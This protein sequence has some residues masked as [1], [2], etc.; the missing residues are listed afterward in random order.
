MKRPWRLLVRTRFI[1][2]HQVEYSERRQIG[3]PRE[4]KFLLELRTRLWHIEPASLRRTNMAHTG[5]NV[6]YYILHTLVATVG[7]MLVTALI[8]MQIYRLHHVFDGGVTRRDYATL[9]FSRGS[10][11]QVAI[12]TIAGYV[13]STRY[14]HRCALWVWVPPLIFLTYNLWS[15]Q[16][17]SVFGG[18]QWM[19]AFEHFFG[20][21]CLV[22][23][24]FDQYLVTMP[25]LTAIAYALGTAVDRLGVLRFGNKHRGVPTDCH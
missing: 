19:A 16:P 8:L 11:V 24:C 21:G 7:C 20:R 3:N 23:W 22:P 10:P 15:W 9:L 14:K 4:I 25:F 12:A 5:R 18:T 17:H 13:V 1:A 2:N 6:A